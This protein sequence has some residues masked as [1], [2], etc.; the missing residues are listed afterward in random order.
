V[1]SSDGKLHAEVSDDGRGFDLAKPS[2]RVAG[3]GIAGMRERAAFLH[4]RLDIVGE[5]ATGTTVRLEV[6]LPPAHERAADQVRVLLVED[7]AAVREAIA[8]MFERESDL[9]VVGQAE[10]LAAARRLLHGVDV[11]VL[12]LALPDGNG[13]ALIPELRAASPGAQVLVLSA[14][15][16]RTQTA[17]AIDAGAAGAF[18][19]TAALDQVVVAIRRLRAGQALLPSQEIDELLRVASDR[20]EQEREDREAIASL[21]HREREVL[22]ALAAG[23]DGQTIAESLGISIRTERNHVARILNK[24]GVHTQ[25]QAVLF[26]LRYGLIDEP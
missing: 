14:D 6:P 10:S 16:D 5:P 3:H 21:T 17:R 13:L 26:G 8:G 11:A 23:L 1:W 7:H 18:D 22:K 12:D 15:L 2:P 4:G 20:R 19:K 9:T 25:L 24:L